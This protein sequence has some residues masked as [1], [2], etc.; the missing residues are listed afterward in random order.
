MVLGAALLTACASQPVPAPQASL[1][2]PAAVAPPPS[3]PQLVANGPEMTGTASWYK[4]GPG[5]HRTCTGRVFTANGLTAASHTIPL[6]TKVRVALLDDTSRSV[7]VRVD[8]CM[9]H[10]RRILDLSEG[11]AREL[12]MVGLG[13]AQVSVTPVVLVDSR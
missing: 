7:V 11:A 5:L 2:P 13:V 1:R 4:P 6:G 10:G 12:G 3:A 8:D 9:P